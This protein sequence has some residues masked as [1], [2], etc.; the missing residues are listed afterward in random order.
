MNNRAINKLDLI[1]KIMKSQIKLLEFNEEEKMK[2]IL[3]T[4]IFHL[5]ELKEL[6]K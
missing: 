5:D 3:Q 2:N 1:V 6:I 4:H